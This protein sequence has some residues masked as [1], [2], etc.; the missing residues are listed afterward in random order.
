M[1]VYLHITAT[2]FCRQVMAE[3]GGSD[4]KIYFHDGSET[5]LGELLPHSFTLKKD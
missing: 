2:K 3:F 1:E 4:M 5:T